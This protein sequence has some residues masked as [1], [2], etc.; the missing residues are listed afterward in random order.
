MKSRNVTNKNATGTGSLGLAHF[1][2][3]LGSKERI[4][5]LTSRLSIEGFPVIDGPRITGD[6]YCESVV[7]DLEGNRIEIT[8]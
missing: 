2:V 3:S 7:L 8:I 1:A 4:D 6:G 5:G